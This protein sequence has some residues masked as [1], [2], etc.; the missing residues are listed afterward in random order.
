MPVTE[1][2]IKQWGGYSGYSYFISNMDV[3]AST[4]FYRIVHINCYDDKDNLKR[5]FE[6]TIL[7]QAIDA[8]S[9]AERVLN[10]LLMIEYQAPNLISKKTSDSMRK[11]DRY[12]YVGVNTTND[13]IY[14]DTSSISYNPQTDIVKFQIKI[15]FDKVSLKNTSK[16]KRFRGIKKFLSQVSFVIGY[17]YMDLSNNKSAHIRSDW[18]SDSNFLKSE[19]GPCKYEPISPNDVFV[20]VKD[21]IQTIIW[22]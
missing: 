17:Y 13:E 3:N 7:W 6:A 16:T 21:M 15:I 11:V 12:A 20:K 10:T 14:L 18:Y 5:S 19:E 4:N 22:R 1:D 2:N 9:P 8:G